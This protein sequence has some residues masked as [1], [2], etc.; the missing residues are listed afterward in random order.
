VVENIEKT[1]NMMT[2]IKIKD[3]LTNQL[4]KERV[5]ETQLS[6]QEQEWTEG[7]PQQHK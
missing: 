5:L 1:R 3:A 7:R 2:D 6:Q 4:A